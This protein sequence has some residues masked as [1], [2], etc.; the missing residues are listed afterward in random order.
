MKFEQHFIIQDSKFQKHKHSLNLYFD[1]SGILRSQTRVNKIKGVALPESQPILIRSNSYYTEFVVLKCHNEVK[2][3]GL[4]STLNRIRCKHWL[5]RGQ[6]T[7]KSITRKCVTCRLMQVKCV[8]PPPTPLLPEHR[9]S[10]DFPFQNVGVDYA[11]PLYVRDN[12]SKSA[13]LFKAYILVFTCATT[14]CTHLEL[15]TDFTT[16][17]LILV[18]KRFIFRRDK[19]YFFISDNVKTFI[20]KDLKRFLLKVGISWKY[21]SEKSPRW[22][23]FYEGI[24]GIIKNCL[25]KVIWKSCFRYYEIETVLVEIEHTLNNVPVRGKLCRINYPSSSI[26]WT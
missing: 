17:T 11:G 10:C 13:E 18:I 14:R 3:L 5:I 1:E 21:F 24:I 9:V 26:I 16:E 22:G 6:S 20:S 2:H 12:Y 7:V 15:A 23:G 4:E 19:P 25:K 8:Q